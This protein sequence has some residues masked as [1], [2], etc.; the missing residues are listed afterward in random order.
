MTTK[1]HRIRAG[2]LAVLVVLGGAST[3]A[4]GAVDVTGVADETAVVADGHDSAP[5][6]SANVQENQTNVTTLENVTFTSLI[7]RNVT[8]VNGTVGDLQVEQNVS[9]QGET[10]TIQQPLEN[11]TVSRT[12]VDATLADVVIRNLTVRNET[13]ARQL[14]VNATGNATDQTVEVAV[15]EGLTIDGL[16]VDEARVSQGVVQLNVTGNVTMA[17]GPS[18]AA[19]APPAVEIGNVTIGS[20]TNA[21]VTVA[22]GT[23]TAAEGENTGMETTTVN[24]TEG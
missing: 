8:I 23:E 19:E 11:A 10:G 18:D 12:E 4:L 15:L 9:V 24:E 17:V 21:S 20:I 13:I 16:V 14:L 2:L 1:R 5:A 6:S 22:P 7:L 3:L